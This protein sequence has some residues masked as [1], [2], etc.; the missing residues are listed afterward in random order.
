M[1]KKE[2]KGTQYDFLLK[3]GLQFYTIQKAQLQQPWHL[4]HHVAFELY[5]WNNQLGDKTSSVYKKYK[6][7]K[8]IRDHAHTQQ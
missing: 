1:H 8:N 5:E 3:Q 4:W 2:K 6:K 7:K